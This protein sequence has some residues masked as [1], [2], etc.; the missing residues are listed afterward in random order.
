MKKFKWLV[1]A[2]VLAFS[3]MA[4]SKGVMM[5]MFQ[6]KKQLNVLQDAETT[7]QF[8]T[9]VAAFLL[10]AEK[11]KETMPAS[12]EGDQERFVGYQAAMQQV[13][14]VAKQAEQQAQA[15]NL[16]QAKQTLEALDDMKKKYHSEYK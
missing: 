1:V 3:S 8:Q 6:M 9:S 4:F 13:I 14:D 10:Q 2:T 11:A 7:E 15:G 12:L 16:E 5:E